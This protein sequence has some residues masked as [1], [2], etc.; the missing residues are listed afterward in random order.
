[1]LLY[2]DRDET[3]G[4]KS[5]FFFLGLRPRFSR[6]AASLLECLG[7]ACSKF[8]KKNKRLLAVYSARNVP[9]GEERGGETDVFVGYIKSSCI[10]HE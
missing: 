10:F 6:Q 8:A 9:I 7:F 2:R 3:R 5:Y 1:M 4:E